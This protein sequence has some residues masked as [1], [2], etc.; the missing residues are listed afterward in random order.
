MVTRF[1]LRLLP[2]YRDGVRSSGYVYPARLY[3]PVFSWVLSMVPILDQD[4]EITALSQFLDGELCF[5]VFLV[6]MKETSGQAAEAL[7]ALHETRIPGAL[8]EWFCQEDSLENLYRQKAKSNPQGHRW[9]SSNT[10]L[11]SKADV[12]IVDILEGGFLTLPSAAS[13]AFWCP[14]TPT[15]RRKLPDMAFSMQSDYYFAVYAGWAD[16]VDDERCQ[17]WLQRVMD[18]IKPHGIGAYIGDSDFEVRPDR[19]WAKDNES[20]LREIRRRW[21]PDGRFCGFP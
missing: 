20:R 14:I 1:H 6:C 4:T 19:Y 11:E 2:Y 13:Y 16:E 5:S 17:S 10:Y 12:D 21:D 15:S 9:C 7:Q 3:R 8:T 18:K